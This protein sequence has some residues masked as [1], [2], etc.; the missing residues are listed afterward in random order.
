MY[1]NS[2][3]CQQNLHTV[4]AIDYF[5]AQQMLVEFDCQHNDLLLHLF[6]ALQWSLRQ[7]HNCLP[8]QAIADQHCWHDQ[9]TAH[10]GYQFPSLSALQQ[11]IQVLPISS[12]NIA[13]KYNAPV[14]FDY[15]A[16][17][18]RRYWLF[19]QEV[20]QSLSRRI[21]Q[22]CLEQV[23]LA[24][25]EGM[26][27]QLF[28]DSTS[29]AGQVDW[30]QV[31]VANALGR[32]FTVLAGGPGTGKTFTVTRLL[33]TLIAST[34]GAMQIKMAAPT[35]KA[36]QRLK[37][38][39]AQ[40]KLD[41]VAKGVEQNIIDAIPEQASTLHRLLGFRPQS[42]Q[43]Q[44]HRDNQLACDLLL[45][46]EVSMI[47]MAMMARLLRALPDRCILVFLGDAQ[48]L[49]SVESGRL[50]ADLSCQPHPGYSPQTAQ[51][52]QKLTA[53]QVPVVDAAGA[54]T[55]DHLTLLTKSFRFGGEIG[56]LATEVIATQAKASWQRLQQ[57][58][59]QLLPAEMD[60]STE[61]VAI[62]DP[63]DM[64]NIT[65]SSMEQWLR[66]CCE[67]YYL[68]LLEAKTADQAF[69]ALAQ[70][71]ILLATRV[72][73]RGVE[74]VNRQIEY[75]LAAHQPKVIAGSHYGGR[76]IMVTQNSYSTGL[77]NGDVGI[78]WRQADG[79]LVALFEQQGQ[80]LREVSLARLPQVEPVYAMTIHKT[81]GS[82]FAHVAL[83]L[84]QHPS[85]MI[86]PELIYTGI[87]RAKKRLYL[88]ANQQVWQDGL[89]QRMT[90]YS[91]LSQRMQDSQ[92]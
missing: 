37:E 10:Q 92:K 15:Q 71:R 43:L 56:A 76:P 40:A 23:D 90:R 4:E 65:D 68:P 35:G 69:A 82:E 50:M 70:F 12:E 26:I 83:I 28:S 9:E 30:Q 79:R 8:L 47:D 7:G 44:Y 51:H 61:L 55:Y 73:A 13:S 39:I 1:P 2:D 21:S 88:A 53:Q 84:P 31:A 32:R 6:I 86:S 74:Q 34:T 72:G 14:V 3:S 18:L 49:P 91:N 75:W 42:T 36:A 60:H 52:M 77:F 38:S 66:R 41:L 80:G 45:V 87:T 29:I 57:H 25:A 54:A 48:Q 5:F 24:R 17:Y 62:D 89:K 81:Q 59:S 22:F 46:D 16:L 78:I 33:A 58:R 64:A 27:R 85:D 67:H 20:A 19:E 11:C 63:A